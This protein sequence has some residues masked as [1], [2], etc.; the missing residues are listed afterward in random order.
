MNKLALKTLLD[1]DWSAT[2][3]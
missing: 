3:W 2:D 1:T